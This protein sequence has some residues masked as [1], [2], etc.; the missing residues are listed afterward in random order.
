[1]SPETL[2]LRYGMNPHQGAAALSSSEGDLPIKVLNGAPGFI[3]LLDALNSWQL[4]IELK[5]AVGLP[6]AS[7]FKHVSP[8]GA[9]VASPLSDTLRKAWFVG[10]QELSPLATAY[11]RARGADRVSAYGDFAALS[12]TVDVSTA[13]VLRRE[14]SDAV[15]APGYEPEALEILSG[16]KGGRYLII[17]ADPDFEPAEVESRDV[18][19]M[20][21]EQQ[22]DSRIPSMDDLANVVT[23]TQVLPDSA[24]IDM[25]VS[26]VALKYT[27]SNSVCLAID[28]QIIGMGA[29]Q[30]S[31]IHCTRL[32]ASKAETWWLRQHPNVM[33]LEFPRGTGRP[34]RDN[35]ID[36]FL[37]D[38]LTD[39]EETAMGST[40][41]SPPS[42]LSSEAKREWI[43][44]LTGV[45]LG[46]DAFI[47]FRDNIDR[48]AKT[49]VKYVVQAGNSLRDADVIT[50]CDQYGM[51]MVFNGVRLF[52]H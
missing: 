47:P 10:S 48:A 15:I 30:Q 31:R 44:E 17:E 28:G 19:G 42:R 7:C 3:N 45:T 6:S 51:A 37:S 39:E 11:V 13:R 1:M 20:R 22:R 52:H 50:A 35:A 26:M 27:Q 5:R 38:D 24:K 32:A 18:F 9:A 16:K 49:G 2:H 8:V 34:D 21:M 40:F 41:T 29:G 4:A 33:S 36:Q 25:L 12:D 14:V 46:S 43:G 23:A